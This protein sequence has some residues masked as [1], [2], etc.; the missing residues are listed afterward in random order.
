[1][2]SGLKVAGK[3]SKEDVTE[4]ERITRSKWYWLKLFAANWHGAGII[5]GIVWGTISG[6]LG[7]SSPNWTAMAVIWTVMIGIIA[8]AVYSTRRESADELVQLNRTLPDQVKLTTEGIT[9]EG[10]EGATRFMH[11]RRFKG[12]HEGKRIIIV[13]ESKSDSAVTLSIGDLSE[14]ERLRV[15]QILQSSIPSKSDVAT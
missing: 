4:F 3:L 15:R 5:I 9:L 2:T 6:L 7:H 12:W 10:P 8:W 14:V 1:M 13:N 11:W